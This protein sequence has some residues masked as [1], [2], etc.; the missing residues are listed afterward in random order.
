V[1]QTRAGELARR[2]LR[3]FLAQ[4]LISFEHTDYSLGFFRVDH[5]DV[6][7][8]PTLHHLVCERGKFGGKCLNARFGTMR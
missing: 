8:E 1:Y 6:L 3:K 7:S 4:F 5:R 2:I